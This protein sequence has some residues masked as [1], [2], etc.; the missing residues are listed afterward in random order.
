[1][2]YA[3]MADYVMHLPVSTR[4]CYVI[5]SN[6]DGGDFY[7]FLVGDVFEIASQD[8]PAERVR[9]KNLRLGDEREWGYYWFFIFEHAVCKKHFE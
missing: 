2:E 7:H 8:H 4:F 1:M 3:Q 5:D 9:I 6:R